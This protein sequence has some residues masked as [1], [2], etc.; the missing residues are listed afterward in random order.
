MILF[1]LTDFTV[2]FRSRPYKRIV[3]IQ[4]VIV[5]LK[6]KAIPKTIIN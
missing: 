6:L 4:L 2:S 5:K 3:V 1:P